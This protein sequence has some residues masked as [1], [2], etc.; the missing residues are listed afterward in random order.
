MPILAAA[1]QATGLQSQDD[2]DPILGDQAKQHLK[3]M[4][5]LGRRG[6]LSLIVVQDEDA[7]GRPAELDGTL[8]ESVLAIGLFSVINYLLLG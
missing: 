1:T 3:V 2:A 8:F 7:R 4:T 6:A 5:G